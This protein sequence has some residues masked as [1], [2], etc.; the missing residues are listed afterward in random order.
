M[1]DEPYR[2][3]EAMANRREYVETQLVA[4]SPV[5]ALNYNGGILF[6]TIAPE[7]QKIFEIYDR[8]ALGAMGHPGDVER[9]R[10]TAIEI[11]SAEGFTRSPAD[12]SLRRLANFSFSPLLKNTFEQVYGSVFIV[13][14]L[15][16]ELGATSKTDL[17][18]RVDF[19]GTLQTGGGATRKS[20][21]VLG[22]TTTAEQAMN[23]FLLT[24]AKPNLTLD[25][26]LQIALLTWA[27]GSQV[28]PVDSPDEGKLTEIL[29]DALSSKV[30]EAAVLDR[31]TGSK[32]SYRTLNEME[33]RKTVNR[34]TRER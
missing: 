22:G 6:L 28:E 12:V 16:A 20:F 26:A 19:D 2:Y 1:T 8:I 5:V 9:L 15:F 34:I 31:N 32:V 17:F 30:V 4:A 13:R 3:V 7:P 18:V 27:V 23:Q 14:L 11:A 29:R 24:K 21:G 33:L 25:A 10:M